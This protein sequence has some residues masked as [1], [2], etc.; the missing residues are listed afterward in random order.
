MIGCAETGIE[1]VDFIWMD[2][3]GAEGRCNKG[4]NKDLKENKVSL[5]RI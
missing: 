1:E 4:G 5:H 2:V 3:Q